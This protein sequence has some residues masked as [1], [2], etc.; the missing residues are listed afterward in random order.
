MLKI[1]I[2]F[3]M[4]VTSFVALQS[5]NSTDI[6]ENNDIDPKLRKIIS[7]K[8]DSLVTAMTTSNL[9]I[10]YALESPEYKKHR[11]TSRVRPSNLFKKGILKQQYKVYDEFLVTNTER[12]VETGVTSKKHGYTFTFRN[13][14]PQSFVSLL[15][16]T[17]YQFDSVIAVTYGLTDEGW[18]I[19]AVDAFGFGNWGLSSADYYRMEKQ[20]DEKGFLINAYIYARNASDL[21]DRS[22][23]VKLKWNERDD[24]VAYAKEL[25]EEVYDKYTFPV[26]LHR[27]H[28]KPTIIRIEPRAILNEIVP[29]VSYYTNISVTETEQLNQERE[30][31]KRELKNLF[32]K[33]M[34]LNASI[35]Y[36]A[37]NDPDGQGTGT[38]MV[39]KNKKSR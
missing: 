1:T 38:Y 10:Y 14:K 23:N 29:G 20:Q 28:T 15:K 4:L 16:V 33:D 24:I 7:A 26:V 11:Q 9:Q 31:I 27:V 5:C 36:R 25:E 35:L 17:G 30:V 39:D 32:K 6:I 2:R 13:D 34:D 37:Y 18:K 21:I 19:Y 12:Y 3:I 22:E 8:N